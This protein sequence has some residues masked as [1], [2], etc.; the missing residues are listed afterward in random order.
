MPRILCVP[1]LSHSRYLFLSSK[2]SQFHSQLN[3]FNLSVTM[4]RP[5]SSRNYYNVPGIT[6]E[7]VSIASE[8]AFE[9]HLNPNLKRNGN[10]V[11]IVWF[12]NDLRVLD[13]EALFTAWAASEFVLPV[14]CVDP[15]LFGTTHY[16]GFP[17]TGGSL[18]YC[19]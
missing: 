5:R 6:P 15:R 16:F 1:S 12:R 14:Y 7:E 9:R 19:C 8:E 18:N 3:T 4:S 11:V 17:K 2:H 10:G 13:N